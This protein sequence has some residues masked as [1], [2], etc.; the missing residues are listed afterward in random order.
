MGLGVNRAGMLK[1]LQEVH[2]TIMDASFYGDI[3]TV[4]DHKL[5]GKLSNDTKFGFKKIAFEKKF[6]VGFGN[7]RGLP[8]PGQNFVRLSR[9]VCARRVLLPP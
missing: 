4:L 6:L 2:N 5:K 7:C 9:Q 1:R 8:D 3:E